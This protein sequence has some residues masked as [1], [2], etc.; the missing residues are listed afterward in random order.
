MAYD[1]IDFVRAKKNNNSNVKEPENSAVKSYLEFENS[2]INPPQAEPPE[3]GAF[4]KKAKSIASS[5]GTNIRNSINNFESN[6]PT[7]ASY[8]TKGLN[9]AASGV[10][11]FNETA[12]VKKITQFGLGMQKGTGLSLL[13]KALNPELEKEYDEIRKQ[14]KYT[15]GAG[16]IAGAILPFSKVGKITAKIAPKILPKIGI[17]GKDTIGKIAQAGV[18]E[19]MTGLGVGGMMGAAEGAIDYAQ[20][21]TENIS[22]IF[23][24]AAGRAA[25]YALGG[26][27]FGGAAKGVGI[28][29]SKYVSPQIKKIFGNKS[30]NTVNQQPLL[31]NAPKD[32]IEA[33]PPG[34]MDVVNNINKKTG[35]LALPEAKIP[36][37]LALPPGKPLALPQRSSVIELQPSK[38]QTSNVNKLSNLPETTTV[39]KVTT[40][41]KGKYDRDINNFGEKDYYLKNRYPDSEGKL[42]P[43]EDY[44][45][46]KIQFREKLLDKSSNIV[47]QS[48]IKAVENKY[49]KIFDDFKND[50][51][52]EHYTK[53]EIRKIRKNS[54]YLVAN[55]SK[56]KIVTDILKKKQV[57][58]NKQKSAEVSKLYDEAIIRRR[59]LVIE[60]AITKGKMVPDEILAEF[61]ILKKKYDIIKNR[62]GYGEYNNLSVRGRKD[63]S[64]VDSRQ[65]ERNG[66]LYNQKTYKETGIT[67]KQISQVPE[68]FKREYP[69]SPFMQ[70]SKKVQN[71]FEVLPKY[72][73]ESLN[74]KML[75]KRVSVPEKYRIE[76]FELPKEKIVKKNLNP[77]SSDV[78]FSRGEPVVSNNQV[79]G[80]SKNTSAAESNFKVSNETKASSNMDNVKAMNVD[81]FNAIQHV[82]DLPDYIGQLK[83][84]I[85]EAER[86]L[87]MKQNENGLTLLN[88]NLQLFA[89]AQKKL[90]RLQKNMAKFKQLEGILE[91]SDNWKDKSPAQ[92]SRETWDRNAID[93]A[94]AK[95]GQKL[96]E[97]VFDKIHE[98][99]AVST[100]FKNHYRDKVKELKLTAEESKLTQAFGEG[101]I[102]LDELQNLTPNWQKIQ[103]AVKIFRGIYNELLTKANKVLVD[104]FY[105]PIPFRKDY[106]P[107]FDESDSFLR[108]FGIDI[109]SDTLP[110]E[111]S[112]STADFRPGKNWFG[113]FLSRKGDNTKL[114]AVQGFDRYIEG[115]SKVIHHTDDIQK[116]RTL[117]QMVRNKYSEDGIESVIDD[118]NDSKFNASNEE[119]A[120]IDGQISELLGKRK[121]TN[122]SN[123]VANLDEYTNNLAGKKAIGD[124]GF[125]NTFGRMY[126]VIDAA[127]RRVGA[128]MVAVN[129]SSWLTNTVPLV[130]AAAENNKAAVAKALKDTMFSITKNDG[131]VDK[132]MFLTNRVGSDPIYLTSIQKTTKFLTSPFRMIDLFTSQVVTRAKYYDAIAKG[133]P[134]KQAI[135]IADDWAAKTMGDRSLGA[136]PTLFTQKNPLISLFTQ[137]QLEVNNQLSHV[138][139]DLPREFNRKQLVNV[140]A[141]TLLYAYLYNKMFKAITGNEP[142]LDPIGMIGNVYEDATNENLSATQKVAN[143]TKHATN[144]IPFTSL[145]A[146]G[147]ASTGGRLPISAAIPNITNMTTGEKTLKELSK[148]LFYL[149]P[150]V[151]GG[152]IKKTIEGVST[153]LD[154][155]DYTVTKNGKK[156]YLYKLEKNLYN[157]GKAAIFGKN[158]LKEVQDY[159]NGKK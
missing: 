102:T 25:E 17:V 136:V 27:A 39:N 90:T 64:V 156:K 94:G 118:L 138:F 54:N 152:Q 56:D 119:L 83:S 80:T 153:V 35:V 111:I 41:K 36:N 99:E 37:R 58:I 122:L 59:A 45:L 155:G 13:N 112:G 125:E 127:K 75:N 69:L 110:T 159:Y 46:S 141:Q 18:T 101:K 21:N 51:Y 20:G 63:A 131:F 120:V 88:I 87:K 47:S 2:V 70:P 117:N 105:D 150:P 76:K 9:T 95:E 22:D 28:G 19:A 114:D 42:V 143:I 12:P 4:S 10:K 115:I 57:E 132:S 60:D 26:L 135:K 109:Y 129:L 91:N 86:R 107:H 61:P 5:I 38:I 126:S 73:K 92:Y 3:E 158:S 1:F 134:E 123:F 103:N 139:K 116:L 104:N 34:Y 6:Y 137:F 53:G 74:P 49:S 149:V 133:I 24:T 50:V 15:A 30:A 16:E 97:F 128:N 77:N 144:P 40:F 85:K 113:N 124:R 72:R 78:V 147:G 108:K 65:A 71:P 157:L 140:G 23:K 81:D 142:A 43:K 93:V 151:G 100:K 68:N 32:V 29:F 106:F 52:K 121:K 146:F 84:Y 33:Y 130:N 98:N 66:T 82:D 145:L 62:G 11:A 8:L 154:G 7:L 148:P 96:K 67:N 14:N 44:E 55:D 31:L 48:E 89:E 79:P